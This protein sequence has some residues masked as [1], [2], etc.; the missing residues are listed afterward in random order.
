MLLNIYISRYL[1]DDIWVN[2]KSFGIIGMTFV[3]MIIT[4]LYIYRYLPQ[5][6]QEKTRNNRC[7]LNLLIVKPTTISWHVTAQNLSDAP[8]TPMP[9]AIF[10]VAGSCSNGH[11]R[12][13]F[14]KRNRS[15]SCCNRC[16]RKHE[17]CLRPVS[18]G[19]VVCC[20]GQCLYVGRSSIK[21]K[22]E[23]WVKKW[24]ANLSASV[25]A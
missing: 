9:T 17:F 7:Q 12:C 15:W 3:A 4:G 14:S 25:I 20:Y 22:V 11:W 16:C 23:V 5:T 1:S 19:D 21:I 13:N 8:Q 10:S 2:F 24:Q 18:V 6:Q